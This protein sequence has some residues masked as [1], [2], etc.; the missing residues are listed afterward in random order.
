VLPLKLM[1]PLLCKNVP[2]FTKLPA[3]FIVPL[4]AVRVFV[5]ATVTL[6]KEETLDPEIAVEPPN[7]VVAEPAFKVPLLTKF[8]LILN[9]VD[10]VKLPVPE[11][12]I[13]PKVGVALPEIIVVPEN[14]IELDVNVDA[15]LLTKLPFISMSFDPE[16][17]EPSERVRIPFTVISDASVRAPDPC[18]VIFAKAV[19]L[20]GNS[21]PVDIE[22]V[23]L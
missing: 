10:G 14:V 17:K 2:L 6:L 9:E 1:E 12:V 4:G 19:V 15:A 16:L 8:P 7:V 22:E 13:P 21:G 18:F 20:V 23:V 3:I 5:L 11:I